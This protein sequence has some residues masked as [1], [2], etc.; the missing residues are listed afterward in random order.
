MNQSQ[1]YRPSEKIL[2]LYT[3]GCGCGFRQSNLTPRA[4]VSSQHGKYFMNG[5]NGERRKMSNSK[6]PQTMNKPN[7]KTKPKLQVSG[8]EGDLSETD[9]PMIATSRL[10]ATSRR[11][12]ERL[13]TPQEVAD[14]LGASTDWVYDHETGATRDCARSG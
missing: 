3:E 10:I 7:D 4:A 5:L 13:W 11:E 1:A 8:P 14:Y 12:P 2:I 9:L 6:H